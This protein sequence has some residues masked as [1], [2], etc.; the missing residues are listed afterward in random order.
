VR[1]LWR[2]EQEMSARGYVHIAGVDEAGR[3]PLA[4]PVVAAAAMLPR[5]C[6]LPG[7]KDSKLLRAE[8]RER[9]SGLIWERALGVGV[10]VVAA[11]TVDRVNVLA[12]THLAM[13]KAI[14]QLRPQPDVLLVDGRGLPHSPAPQRAVVGGDRLCGSIAAASIVAKVVRD[15]IMSELDELYPEYGF[16]QHKGYATREHLSRLRALGP[17]PEH[18]LTFGPVRQALQARLPLDGSDRRMALP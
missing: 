10:G 12:A 9:L 16:A 18:R 2:I 4:G 7:L 15:R 1:G 5:R 13:Q 3:G 11:R 17:C 14:A 6:R 8:Q